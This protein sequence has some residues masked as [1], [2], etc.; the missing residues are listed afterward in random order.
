MQGPE[1]L[2]GWSTLGT[3]STGCSPAQLFAGSS[4]GV[5]NQQDAAARRA[6]EASG[7]GS[8]TVRV[9]KLRSRGLGGF[10]VVSSSG[11]GSCWPVITARALDCHSRPPPSPATSPSKPA[12]GLS[13]GRRQWRTKNYRTSALES[14]YRAGRQSG[15]RRE[16]SPY[17]SSPAGTPGRAERGRPALVYLDFLCAGA[18]GYPTHGWG[19]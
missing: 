17:S 2:K 8:F 4:G 9:G 7:S 16:S 1:S 10:S 3:P 5:T 6:W 12:T 19:C 14:S 15:G 18:D 11:A 13:P